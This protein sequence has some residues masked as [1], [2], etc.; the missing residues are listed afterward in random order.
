MLAVTFEKHRHIQYLNL[1]GNL[2]AIVS[3]RV[4]LSYCRASCHV[5]VDAWK[6][7]ELR[8]L[9]GSVLPLSVSRCV[10]EVSLWGARSDPKYLPV[11]SADLVGA[12]PHTSLYD[13]VKAEQLLVTADQV[14][15]GC[16]A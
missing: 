7:Y 15:W 9:C 8:G 6:R 5:R 2:T 16:S 11:T 13:G 10:G 1:D 14:Q 4:N 12:P 3:L